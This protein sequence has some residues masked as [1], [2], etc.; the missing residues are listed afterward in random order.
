MPPLRPAL[1]SNPFAMFAI[2]HDSADYDGDQNGGSEDV[3]DE[4]EPHTTLPKWL[5]ATVV[6]RVS[7]PIMVLLDGRDGCC[8]CD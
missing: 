8:F 4:V 2:R 6:R 5:K 7:G 1:G 3:E